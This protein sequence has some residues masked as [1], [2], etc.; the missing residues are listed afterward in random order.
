MIASAS[1]GRATANSKVVELSPNL[2]LHRGDESNALAPLGADSVARS[3]LG[4]LGV[5]SV[6]GPTGPTL[7]ATVVSEVAA[8]AQ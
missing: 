4:P 7:D 1:A 8:S 2:H 3:A 5:D 6:A